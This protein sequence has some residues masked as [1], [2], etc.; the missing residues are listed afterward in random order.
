MKTIINKQ[1]TK[2]KVCFL[3]L[4][5][6]VILF[7]NCEPVKPIGAEEKK[8]TPLDSVGTFAGIDISADQSNLLSKAPLSDSI[9]FV[10]CKATEGVTYTDPNYYSNS[11]IV[12]DKKLISGA[13]HFYHTADD[14][15]QQANA[16]WACL[17]K[18]TLPDMPPILDIEQGSFCEGKNCI[19]PR[20]D[21]LQAQLLR[22]LNRIEQLCNCTPIVYTD[23][24]FINPFLI[25]TAFAK[26]PLWLA[27]YTEGGV[28]PALPSESPWTT[29]FMWQKTD[30]LMINGIQTDFDVYNGKKSDLYK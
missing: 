1:K 26:Y 22:F 23:K 17:S 28:T 16:F 10:I 25:N 20:T 19:T 3:L 2:I 11:K 8:N 18:D 21:T 30:S 12:R 24:G 13:Y 4:T 27:E 14:P 5:T 6:S 9:A 29:Y 15:I 7:G